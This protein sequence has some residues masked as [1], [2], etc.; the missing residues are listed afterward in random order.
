MSSR[1]KPWLNDLKNLD[2]YLDQP[3]RAALVR[4]AFDAVAAV[5]FHQLKDQCRRDANNCTRP[6]EEL[7][8]AFFK[9]MDVYWPEFQAMAANST[10]G[11]LYGVLEHYVEMADAMGL[12]EWRAEAFERVAAN[13]GRHW[14]EHGCGV[15]S[16]WENVSADNKAS[17]LSLQAANYDVSYERFARAVQ[18]AM[19]GRELTAE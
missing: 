13:P 17:Y 7:R 5:G 18:D 4:E 9:E 16:A 1:T 14:R 11:Q 12:M 15:V 2:Y 6:V 3:A 8:E 10:D 19:G